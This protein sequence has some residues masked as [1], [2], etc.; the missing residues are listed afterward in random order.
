M[1]FIVRELSGWIDPGTLLFRRIEIRTLYE[2][3]PVTV[4]ANYS[5]LPTGESYMAQASVEYPEKEVALRIDNYDY[6]PGQ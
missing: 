5:K 3:K 1:S 4:T 2:K 6:H